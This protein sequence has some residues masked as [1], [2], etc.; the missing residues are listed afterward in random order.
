MVILQEYMILNLLKFDKVIIYVYK[1]I[2]FKVI[3]LPFNKFEFKVK[4]VPF[5]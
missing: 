1:F 2:Y 3:S 4:Y 5:T